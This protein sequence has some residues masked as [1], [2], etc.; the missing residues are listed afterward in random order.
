M[1]TTLLNSCCSEPL[2][3]AP[4]GQYLQVPGPPAPNPFIPPSLWP[5]PNL[6][7]S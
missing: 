4:R 6:E 1:G 3:A 5:F 7:T 2:G